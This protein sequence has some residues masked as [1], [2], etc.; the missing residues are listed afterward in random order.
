LTNLNQQL[1][2]R[3]KRPEILLAPGVYD[4]LSAVLAE[5]NGAEAV[6]L[7]GASIAY[8]RAARPDIGLMDMTEVSGLLAN[9]RERINLPIIADADNGFGNALNVQRTV[10]AFERAGASAIQL[11]DQTLP[12]RC[13]HLAGKTLVS[14]EEMVGKVHAALDARH[15]TDT[16]IIARTDAISVEGIDHAFDRANAYVEAGADV[17]FVEA[18]RNLED[19]RRTV[20]LF[21]GRVPLL[22]NI[23]EGGET[24]MMSAREL[25]ELGFKLV[26]F[27]GGAVRAIAHTLGEYYASLIENGTNTP[28]RDRMLDFKGINAVVGTDHMLA[29]GE[30]YAAESQPSSGGAE[31]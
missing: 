10:R 16:V 12:K 25:G 19:M 4:A 3:L 11:E 8:T 2:A 5:G 31:R 9:I 20:A 18:L 17:L 29:S 13:G 27:P 6:Y 26:I 28:Y 21:G 7:S 15:D 23:V 30:R 24:P 1:R 14:R 22:V